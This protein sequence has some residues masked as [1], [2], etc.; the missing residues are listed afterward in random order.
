MHNGLPSVERCRYSEDLRPDTK[1]ETTAY[2][3]NRYSPKNVLID[4]GQIRT[5]APEGTRFLVL[6]DNH[7]ATTPVLVSMKENR[8]VIG[9]IMGAEIRMCGDP[10]S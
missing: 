5:D 7:S 1:N 3:E 10:L 2:N 9:F 8:I 6:R 4:V